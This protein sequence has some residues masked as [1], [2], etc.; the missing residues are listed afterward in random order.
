MSYTTDDASRNFVGTAEF[1]GPKP[2]AASA[3]GR[4]RPA[5]TKRMSAMRASLYANT[6]FAPA[7]VHYGA[8][9]LGRA[10]KLVGL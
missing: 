4:A 3:P 1:G 8:R 5:E 9:A 7:P 2:T 10:M 6:L